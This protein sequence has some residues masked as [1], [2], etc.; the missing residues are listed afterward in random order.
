MR[1]KK[2]WRCLMALVLSITMLVPAQAAYAAGGQAEESGLD[3]HADGR[4]ADADGFEIEDGVLRKY[5][6]TATEVVI[7][8]GVTSIES[9]AFM[10]CNSMEKIIIPKEVTSIG[11]YVFSGCSNLATIKVEE[12]NE[13]YDSRENCNA[14]IETKSNTLIKGCKN[15]IIPEG[16]V[17]IGERAFYGCSNLMG[18]KIP[19]SVSSIG[20]EA[21]YGCSLTEINIPEGVKLEKAAFRGCGFI[22]V[23]IPEGMSSIAEELFWQCG[24]LKEINIP[25]SV[26]EIGNWAFEDCKSLEAIV[27]PE[28]VTSIGTCTFKNCVSLTE[29]GIP[30]NVTNIGDWAFSGCSGLTEISIPKRVTNIGTSICYGCSSLA[31]VMVEEGNPVYDS[32][33]DCNAVIET[34]SNTLIAG[35]QNTI[36]PEGLA[37]IGGYAFH[38]RMGLE[39]INIPEGVADIGECAFWQCSNLKEVTI[40][41]SV[42]IIGAGAFQ[43]CSEELVIYGKTGSY[44]EIYAKVNNIKFSSTGAAL[45][46]FERKTIS[47]NNVALSQNSYIYDGTAKKP[48]A[49]VKD[50]TAALKEGT[51][52]TVTYSNNINVGTAKVTITGKGYYTGVVTKEFTITNATPPEQ[53]RKA[54]SQCTVM[55]NNSSYIYDGTAKTP[56]VTVKDGTTALKEGTDYTVTYSNNINV[57]TA[58]ATV[59][60]KGNYTGTVTKEFTITKA[61]Q[62]QGIKEISQCKVTLSKS[63]YAYDG[64]VKKPTATVK[65]GAVTLKEGTDY[66]VAYTNN[67]NAGTAKVTVTGKGNYK[68]AVAKNF[69]ITV[70]KGT[71]HKVGSCQYK[72][73]GTSTVSAAGAKNNKVTKIKI[74]K[75]VKIGGKAFKVTAIASRAFKGNKKITSIEIGDNVKMIGTSAF[76]G[77]TKLGKATLGKGIIEISGNAFTN[78]KKLGTVTIK[79]TKLKKVGRNALKGIKPTAKIKVPAKKLP[80]YKKLF[81]NKGQGRKVKILK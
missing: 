66:T 2:G 42:E 12:G 7:P 43:E 48:M 51:D 59:T 44:A 63:S 38:K 47:S 39:K 68:G 40:P 75:T 52:Y 65:D 9:S 18:I 21:F 60:G 58:K 6:G 29:I 25:A 57:G 61:A 5:T 35:C 64:K 31:S 4:A 28:G 10:N 13:I 77:C 73:T 41:E 78:C 30:G 79:S 62:G 69:T 45:N 22:S 56:T 55:L 20:G 71:S 14:V 49:T 46:P 17:R 36:M 8:E 37:S 81:K 33:E 3:V 50:G 34:G 16:V 74:P 54:L 26:T 11:V 67:I 24:R 23:D 1:K 27:I 19:A 15:T 72:V 76:E 80:A 53:E 32:R 70:K